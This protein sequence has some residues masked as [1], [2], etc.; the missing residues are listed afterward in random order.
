MTQVKCLRN[1]K[2]S[3]NEIRVLRL[4]SIKIAVIV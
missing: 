1:D 2:L 4:L 3:E